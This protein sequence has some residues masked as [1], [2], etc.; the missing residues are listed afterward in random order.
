MNLPVYVAVKLMMCGLREKQLVL[1]SSPLL[2]PEG[3]WLSS[4]SAFCAND[5]IQECLC[6]ALPS[7]LMLMTQVQHSVVLSICSAEHGESL[8]PICYFKNTLML[9]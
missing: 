4:S 3:I 5:P 7:A 8:M 2:L 9:K 6:R 1:S